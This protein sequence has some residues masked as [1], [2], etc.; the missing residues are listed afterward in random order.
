MIT[1]IEL[2]NWKTHGETKLAFSKGT[3]ILIGQM[4]AGKSS[5][6]DAISFALFGTFPSIHHKRVGVGDVIRSRPAKMASATVKLHF[7]MNGNK[8]TVEREVSA[9]GIGKAQ[10]MKDGVYVQSQP[11]RV[12]EEIEKILKINYDI[13]SKAVYSEQ[14]RLDYFLEL[15]SNARKKQMDELLGLD[16]FAT[17]QENVGS[18]INKIK[19]M[20]DETEKAASGFDI[21]KLNAQLDEL[22]KSMGKLITEKAAIEADLEKSIGEKKRS[23]EELKRLR[24]QFNLKVRIEK[25]IAEQ[26][27][28]ASV[29]HSEIEKIDARKL[30]DRKEIEEKTRKAKE[31]MEKLKEEQKAAQQKERRCADALAGAKAELAALEKQK[32]ELAKLTEQLKET[33]RKKTESSVK[34]KSL[35]IERCNSDIAAANVV[36]TE[37]TKWV[38]ELKKHAQKCPVCERELDSEIVAKL[39]EGKNSQITEST[40]KARKAEEQMRSE[41]RELEALTISLNRLS[42]M[43]DKI[44][45]YEGIGQKAEKAAQHL[46]VCESEEKQAKQANDSVREQLA[47]ETEQF[48]SISGAEEMLKRRDDYLLSVSR[49]Q[50]ELEKKQ[51]ELSEIKIDQ[52]KID[53]L[54]EE[55]VAASAKEAKF[56]ADLSANMRYQKEKNVQITDKKEEITRVGVLYEDIAAKRKVAENLT[57]FRLS[58]IETQAQ[59]RKQLVDSIN[60]IM[61][62]IWPELY[63]YGD[64]TSVALEPTPDDYILRVKLNGSDEWGEVNTIASGGERS[65][66]CLAMRI[67]LAMVLAPNLKWIILDEPTHNIDAQGLQKFV[68]MFSES[69]P[70]IVD[71]V[72]II[73]HDEVLKQTYNSKVYVF[74]RNKDEDEETIVQE[75]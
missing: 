50:S 40:A 61:H 39:I 59:L 22:E 71:Q 60:S 46:A 31:R 9:K 37:N 17:A 33:D 23:E 66:A 34:E 44:K 3:N 32:A 67:A 30:G 6:M 42:V 62:E 64:Y 55:V 53:S 73:T 45:G 18:V 13:F 21:K 58:L 48:G 43:E 29:L 26:K 25:E 68:K 4:G 69:M 20:A 5:I 16:K 36:V 75:A 41:K 56:T 51:N 2:K 38:A 70:R 72:F 1:S 47:K 19:D 52:H 15:P 57:K 28:R 8:Y 11:Q 35:M 65:I 49:I 63:P 12:T 7:T 27:S 74:K 10:L 24:E 14:N 54:Q